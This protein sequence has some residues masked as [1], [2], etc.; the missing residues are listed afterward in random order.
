MP[1]SLYRPFRPSRPICRFEPIT[2]ATTLSSRL[3]TPTHY[4]VSRKHP[5]PHDTSRDPRRGSASGRPGSRGALAITSPSH[6]Q[7]SGPAR[8]CCVLRPPRRDATWL[9]KSRFRRLSTLFA[10]PDRSA[11][12]VLTPHSSLRTSR[13]LL[14]HC[15]SKCHHITAFGWWIMSASD[16]TTTCCA[17]V[18]PYSV[19]LI[20]SFPRI[21]DVVGGSS[22]S[23][24]LHCTLPTCYTD[25]VMGACAFP[26][27]CL[28][29]VS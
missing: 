28:G 12:C 27:H 18:R 7:A 24:R 19:T 16:H 1:D 22:H 15:A 14:G 23:V 5:G 6:A 4:A 10:A 26:P 11:D 3:L 29:R 21:A 8:S 17:Y 9:A 13:M 20:L 25:P 2:C